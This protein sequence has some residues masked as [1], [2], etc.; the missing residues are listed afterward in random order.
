MPADTV[1]HVRVML[2]EVEEQPRCPRCK[3]PV[4]LHFL[5]GAAADA[6]TDRSSQGRKS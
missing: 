5:H 3:S 1:P 2:S 4:L 6:D